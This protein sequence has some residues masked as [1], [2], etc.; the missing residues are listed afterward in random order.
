MADVIGSSEANKGKLMKQFV[1]LVA[2]IN[3]EN[4]ELLLSPLTITLGDEFQGVMK[5]LRESL[6]IIFSLE[7]KIF[8]NTPGFSLR[9][10]VVE[11][12]IDTAIN[13]DIAYGMLGD[14]LTIA[15]KYLENLKKS[16]HR[17][18]FNLKDKK[19]EAELNNLFIALQD[20]VDDWDREKDYNLVSK[21][22]ELNDYKAVAL[23]L[24]KERSLMWKRNKSLKIDSY[25]ALKLVANF[26]GGMPY[27]KNNLSDISFFA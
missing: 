14:G 26:I 16:K 3:K 2:E 22:L 18:Y 21:F 6:S 11:G 13:R 19:K 9:Y 24:N 5:G 8:R 10:V 12:T 27:A 1:Q 25:N 4:E 20:I 15:R 17:F 23:N 7:E